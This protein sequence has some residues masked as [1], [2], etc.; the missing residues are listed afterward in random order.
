MF[1]YTFR[2]IS[3]LLV[4]LLVSIH[5]GCPLVF[6]SDD[7]A[8]TSSSLREKIGNVLSANTES[9]L[10]AAREDLIDTVKQSSN[11]SEAA[12]QLRDAM[13]KA[14]GEQKA[15]LIAAFP[16]APC[17]KTLNYLATETDK[18][19]SV[20]RDAV[21]DALYKWPEQ[22]F[23]PLFNGENLDGWAGDTNGYVAKDGKLVCKPGGNLYTKKDYADF[24]VRFEFKLPPGGNNGL[25]IRM[26]PNSHAAYDG[27]EIQILDD[28]ADM[29][30]NIKSY[31]HHGS[32]YGTVPAKTGH[33][34]PVGEWNQEV[35]IAH[36]PWITVILNGTVIVDADVHKASTPKTIDG[37]DHPG[38]K[39]TDGRIGFLGHGT[40][41]EFRDILIQELK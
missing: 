27:M 26:P 23:T 3:C 31:Q 18:E 28:S 5:F 34:K 9:S 12:N 17:D 11:V 15:A 7:A 39:R 21:L 4:A 33:L 30:K 20:I 38:L 8:E 1:Q 24:I 37:R 41:V 14:S 16:C 25:G 13:A 32:V 2:S 22:E 19:T 36:G 29:Y 40:V 10:A 6:A 35:V